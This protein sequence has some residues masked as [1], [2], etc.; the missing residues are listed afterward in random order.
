MIFNII[1]LTI[2][3]NEI[4]CAQNQPDRILDSI[5]QNN[6][7]LSA[8]YELTQSQ[9]IDARTGIFLANPSVT[10][11]R[12]SNTTGH[13]SEFVISQSFDFPTSYKY[14]SRI[15]D[16]SS[17]IATESYNKSRL[18]ILLEASKTYT[19][20]I[21]VNRQI[22]YYSLWQQ[23]ATQLQNGIEK[24]LNAG[25]ANIFEVNRAKSEIARSESELSI[26][27]SKRKNLMIKLNELNGGKSLIVND[28]IYPDLNFETYTDSSLNSIISRNPAI[29]QWESQVSIAE[30]NIRL[31]RALSLP[32]FEAGYRNDQNTGQSY[33]GFHAGITIPL[34]ENKNTV[35]NALARHLFSIEEVNANRLS[36][37][38]QLRELINEYNSLQQSLNNITAIY[39]TLNTP[40]LLLKAYNAGQINY[41]EYFNETSNYN[42][43]LLYIEKL[44]FRKAE[45][46]LQ[47]YVLSKW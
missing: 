28:T 40:Q 20:L 18:D 16:I 46:Q 23:K 14:K 10:Y 15:A 17:T 30:E 6:K 39:N 25:D 41:S 12:L 43:T 32:K 35:R 33:N 3:F 19:E 29:R 11:D 27:S 1:L 8:V 24:R 36:L 26:L 2:S 37:E 42:E 22:N 34:F 47:L 13:Y 45:L 4:V 38:S 5:I 9:K 21:Y 31:T 7:R 44:N